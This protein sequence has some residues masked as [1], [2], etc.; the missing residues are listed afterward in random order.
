MRRLT[1]NDIS[2]ATGAIQELHSCLDWRELPRFMVDLMARLVPCEIATYSEIDRRNAEMRSVHNYHGNDAGRHFPA[3][4]AHVHEHAPSA[5][6]AKTGI[7][8]PLL[9]SDFLTQTQFQRLGL[10][11]EFYR[12]FGIRYQMVFF[13]NLGSDFQLCVGL[14]RCYADFTERERSLLAL[15]SGH[16]AQ[17]WKNARRLTTLE[18]HRDSLATA[19]A[20]QQQGVISL[21][22][23][24][25]TN[26]L[27]PLAERQLAEFFPG[28]SRPDAQLPAPLREWFSR[29]L[30][31]LVAKSDLSY[32]VVRGECRLDITWLRMKSDEFVLL[33]TSST[34]G[35]DALK[36]R[37]PTLTGREQEVLHCL[38][39]GKSNPEIGRILKMSPNTVRKHLERIYAKLGVENR[40]AAIAVAPC[41]NK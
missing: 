14:Q 31:A 27:T 19:L 2:V 40:F 33:L 8:T 11:N 22:G 20:N 7:E 36:S 16:F 37:C 3:F 41:R 34:W 28:E 39:N 10:Y 23:R 5:H 29:T 21:N 26:W 18:S 1:D 24:G 32:E 35:F 15:V 12:V 25:K 6:A 13:P 38:G 17:A 30:R 4:I 9:L